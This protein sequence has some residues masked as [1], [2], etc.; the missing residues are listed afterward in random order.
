MDRSPDDINLGGFANSFGDLYI[1]GKLNYHFDRDDLTIKSIIINEDATFKGGINVTSKTILND[2]T[3][4]S[5]N[6]NVTGNTNVSGISTFNNIEITGTLK[7]GDG[8]TGTAGQI[9]SSDGTDLEWINASSANVGSASKVGVNLDSDS[10]TTMYMTFVDATSG[11]EE[12]RVDKSLTYKPSTGSFLGLTTFTNI[13]VNGDATFTGNSSDLQWDQSANAL[14]FKDETEARF[15]DSN[16]L[17]I[18][19]TDS[20][21]SQDDS[22]G[23]SVLAGTTWA[24][25][26]E[27]RGAGP[28]VF[29]TDGGPSTGA[30][31]LY[32][33]G[34]RPILKLFSG[35]SARAALYHAGAEKLVTSSTGVTVTGTVNATNFTGSGANLTGIEAFVTGMIILWSGAANAIPTGFVLC[36][37]NNSTPN[38]SGK[39][40]VG[41]SASNGDYDVN[42]T[43]GAEDVTLAL[44]Q[45]PSHKHD[46]S[47]DNKKYFPGGGSTSIGYG[48]AGGYPADVF[49]MSNAGGGQAHENRPPYYALCY[50][51]KT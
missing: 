44:S 26:I 6:L 47:F 12:I 11:N 22:N 50:I 39:F 43:G 49:S 34:W 17:I 40:V 23:D 13:E 14:E 18:S 2:D 7:D 28:L 24:S 51:M 31:Q 35:S 38:L 5:G 21:S 42:D 36:D 46:T 16:D 29:K 41:Y 3:D 27:E 15:G 48:G 19:H 32:D 1:T 9:L 37:G 25:Y 30:F 20:L 4:L 8:E 33:T 45:I 10:A